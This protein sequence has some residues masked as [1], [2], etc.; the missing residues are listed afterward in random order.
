MSVDPVVAMKES[1]L[2]QMHVDTS[3]QRTWQSGALLLA[4][5][6]AALGFAL[7]VSASELATGVVTTVLAVGAVTILRLWM[8]FV[9]REKV[10]ARV[11]IHRM[12][13]LENELMMQRQAL[14]KEADTTEASKGLLPNDTTKTLVW[15]GW[16]ALLGWL[17]V[18]IWR[19]AIYAGAFG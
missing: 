2:C 14:I 12:R 10:F 6:V 4:G 15:I 8:G 13:E 18:A 19:W 11:S 1:E 7:Q 16:L 3:S 9:G 17:T 5:V